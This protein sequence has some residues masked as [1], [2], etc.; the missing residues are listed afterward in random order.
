MSK[1]IKEDMIVESSAI[2]YATYY[3]RTKTL[4]VMFTNGHAYDYLA[5]E[6][7]MWEGL[8]ASPSAGAFLNKIIKKQHFTKII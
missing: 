2:Q 4:F 3:Y 6:P 5:V 8:R 7:F 1:I